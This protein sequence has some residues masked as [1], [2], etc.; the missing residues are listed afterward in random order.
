MPQQDTSITNTIL[1]ILL[2]IVVAFIVWFFVKGNVNTNTTPSDNSGLQINV[3]GGD[4]S[5]PQTS[6]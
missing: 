3:G 1:V 2:V 5:Q 6:Q 4:S